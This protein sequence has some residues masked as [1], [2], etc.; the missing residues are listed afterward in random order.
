[1]GMRLEGASL[2]DSG[3]WSLR[4]RQLGGQWIEAPFEVLVKQPDLTTDM[5]TSIRVQV[6]RVA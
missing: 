6:K 3:L 1:M 5:D 2:Y 4:I